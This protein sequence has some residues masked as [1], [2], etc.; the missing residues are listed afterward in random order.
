[1]GENTVSTIALMPR[2]KKPPTVT[3]R[4]DKEL[5]KLLRIAAAANEQDVAD[6]LGDVLRPIL[7]REL[8]KLGRAFSETK[9]EA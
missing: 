5:A 6:Y 9:G 1:M 4:L 3:V 7:A 8:R 2:E